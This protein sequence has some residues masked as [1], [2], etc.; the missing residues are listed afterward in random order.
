MRQFLIRAILRV[1]C[2]FT[3]LGVQ[4]SVFAAMYKWVDEDGITHY[5][6]QPPPDGI[7]AETIKPPPKVDTGTAAPQPGSQNVLTDER[8]E[9]Q[10]KTKETETDTAL[11]EAEMAEK[12]RQAKARLKSFERPRISVVDEKGNYTRLSEEQREAELA[13]S[14]EY[15]KE[16]CN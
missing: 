16:F 5:T 3:V 8:K 7:E 14:K 10:E 15:V 9:E 11:N 12:C 4:Q 6:Q 1:V 13:K 2:C